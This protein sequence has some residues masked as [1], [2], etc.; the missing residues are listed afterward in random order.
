M[1][2]SALLG[3]V[4]ESGMVQLALMPGANEGEI[5]V[6]ITARK[7]E[8]AEAALFPPLIFSGL[9]SEMDAAIPEKIKEFMGQREVISTDLNA[10]LD[11]MR[12][13]AEARKKLEQEKNKPLVK[14]GKGKPAAEGKQETTSETKKPDA[15]APNMSLFGA[16]E[17]SQPETPAVPQVVAPAETSTETDAEAERVGG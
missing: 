13:A 1:L 9:A 6:A 3:Y 17:E 16:L 11:E 10:S 14:A 12:V 2:L 8:K 4:Q 5:K 7:P 15:A